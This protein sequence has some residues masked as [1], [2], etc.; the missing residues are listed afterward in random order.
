[1]PPYKIALKTGEVSGL[2]H[3]PLAPKEPAEEQLPASSAPCEKERGWEWEGDLISRAQ[4]RRKKE[5]S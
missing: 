1:M 2:D 5:D 3:V 4:G